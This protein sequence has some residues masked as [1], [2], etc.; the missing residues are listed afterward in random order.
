MTCGNHT[1]KNMNY[2]FSFLAVFLF[3]T[4]VPAQKQNTTDFTTT[5]HTHLKSITDKDLKG[6]ESTVADSVTL[7]FPN[8]EVLKSKKKFVDFHF[9]WFKD[10]N[11]EMVTEV[12]QTKESSSLAYALVKYQLTSYTDQHQLKSKSTTYLLLIFEKQKTDWKL[13]HDQNTKISSL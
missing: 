9:D 4:N 3:A 10:P 1:Q 8:G 11:W 2:F 12:L 5:L 13:I 7:I 6:I